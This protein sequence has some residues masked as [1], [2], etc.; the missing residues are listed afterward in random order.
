VDE[1]SPWQVDEIIL[2]KGVNETVRPKLKSSVDPQ[3]LKL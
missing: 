2:V 3:S 1:N